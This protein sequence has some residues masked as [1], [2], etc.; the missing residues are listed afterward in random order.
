MDT[1]TY[2]R[3][4][5]VGSAKNKAC[6]A[7]IRA[8]TRLSTGI[9]IVLTLLDGIHAECDSQSEIHGDGCAEVVDSDHSAHLIHV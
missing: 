5:P 2:H 8:G 6:E 9:N 4:S 7:L 3:S 1:P